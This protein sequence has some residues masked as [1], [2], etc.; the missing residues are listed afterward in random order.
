[1]NKKKIFALCIAACMGAAVFAGCTTGT[2]V[3]DGANA[4]F[5][6]EGSEVS[7]QL[8]MPRITIKGNVISWAAVQ[9]ATGYTV[10]EDGE[11]A[12][13]VT[14][15]SYTITETAAGRYTYTVVANGGT[16]YA[17]SEVSNS[18]V[19]A[20]S[21]DIV[22][23]VPDVTPGEP[24]GVTTVYIV[25]DSTV[26][27]FDD[28]YYLPRYG[29]GTQL[30][31]Y[32]SDEV[33]VNNLALSGRSSYSFL[34][35]SNYTIL[36]SNIDGDDFLIIGFGHNDEK[37]ETDRY[38]NPNLSY[39]DSATLINNRPASFAYTLY[40]YYIKVAEDAGATPILCTPIVRANASNDYEGSSGHIT[41]D[42]T[43]GGIAYAGGDYAKA[44]RDLGA[45]TD[46][47][48]IDLTAITKA[49]YTAIGYD[50]ATDYHAWTAT[51]DGVR[52]GVD[53]THTNYFGAKMN[54][55]YIASELAKTDNP[56]GQFVKPDITKPTY[57][58]DYT[59]GINADY[60]EPDYEPFDPATDKSA[61]WT[62]ITEASWYGTAMGDIGGASVSPFTVSQ[63]A[64][65]EGVTFTV[66]TTQSKGKMTDGGDGF[67]AAF[68]Q[69]EANRNFE[70]TVTVT[71]DTYTGDKQT[72]FGL[73]L[74][75]DIY[76]DQQIKN[77]YSNYVA[78][79]AYV[80]GDGTN[81]N[82]ARVANKLSGNDLTTLAQGQSYTLKITKQNQTVHTYFIAGETT[83]EAT[84]TD[85]DFVAVDNQNV[86]LCLFATR[87]TVATFSNIQYTDNGLG[88]EA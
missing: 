64:G 69:L 87:G 18:V 59:A 6:A 70:M 51:K 32:L 76:I 21:G 66:G 8:A 56:L 10:Y 41:A 80:S 28:A 5:V 27:S 78:A 53:N 73:M 47:T 72:G 52:S 31:Q 63:G 77:L 1:M 48:V 49:D 55:Y 34:S 84:Y 79:G 15:P 35:E 43:A 2:S 33:V 39:T 88:V 19:Y 3:S 71:L 74:R 13:T 61:N 54:A 50:K 38:T 17:N 42:A 4:S 20:I 45:A 16:G 12:G 46:T 14:E 57:E 9:N 67:A 85:F 68:M 29:Y 30:G 24:D 75:D 40:N 25:G 62:T 58:V 37:A 82:F 11:V 36:T 23:D 81:I 7:A 60:V 26:S 22:T 83:Y 65:A 44:I 86:Y